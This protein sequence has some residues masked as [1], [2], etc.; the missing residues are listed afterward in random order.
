ML[1]NL[2]ITLRFDGARYHGFQVQE[3]ALSICEAFQDAVQ[4][5][6][7]E[8][9]AV[10]GCSRTDSG[11]HAEMY[12]LSMKTDHTI[13]CVGLLRALNTALPWDI[14]AVDVREVPIDFHARYSCLGKTYRYIIYNAPQ[15]DPFRP[16]RV[17]HCPYPLD[18]KLLNEQAADFC[19]THDFSAFCAAGSSVSDNVRTITAASVIRAG[20]DV[21]FEVSGDGFLYNMVRIMAGTLL[22]IAAEKLLRGSIPQ[23]IAGRERAGAGRT[24]PARGLYLY[25]VEYSDEFG[26][27]T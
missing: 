23:I 9:Y 27:N 12:C 8:R 14:A 11:V 1:R 4:A 20:D 3:N 25:R 26:V 15:R 19:G 21:I 16:T 5:L 10:K 6:L 2:L 17:Y 13:P 24:A 18:A 22:D 7:G